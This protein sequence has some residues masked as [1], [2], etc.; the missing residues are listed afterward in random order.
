MSLSIYNCIYVPLIS[1]QSVLH[2]E[3]QSSSPTNAENIS[4]PQVTT[5]S[6]SA[7]E[8][9]DQILAKDSAQSVHNAWT[10]YY[11]QEGYPYYY[12]HISGESQWANVGEQNC[13]TMEE[14][15]KLYTYGIHTYESSKVTDDEQVKNMKTSGEYYSDVDDDDDIE[16]TESLGGENEYTEDDDDD[17]DDNNNKNGLPRRQKTHPNIENQFKEFLNTPEGQRRLQ[18]EVA[19]MAESFD[20]E[21]PMNN[22]YSGRRTA[23]KSMYNIMSPYTPSESAN[24]IGQNDFGNRVLSV[25]ASI[26]STLGYVVGSITAMATS[27]DS[28][29]KQN[30]P[31][32]VK[33]KVSTSTHLKEK[34]S[35]SDNTP[36]HQSR[37]HSFCNENIDDIE[38]FSSATNAV[39]PVVTAAQNDSTI[40]ESDSGSDSDSGCEDELT[41]ATAPLFPEWVSVS[42]FTAKAFDVVASIRGIAT[43]STS[44]PNSLE[45][46]TVKISDEAADNEFS[47]SEEHIVE[48]L[49]L[50][51]L[52]L[53]VS[54]MKSKAYVAF[55]AFASTALSVTEQV[56]VR[57]GTSVADIGGMLLSRFEVYHFLLLFFSL[58]VIQLIHA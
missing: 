31:V 5:S 20:P 11:S 43:S 3:S 39:N 25:A 10:L 41:V 32:N 37:K 49:P 17:D 33:V 58:S 22:L 47:E 21:T 46:S 9:K 36:S 16:E 34:Q 24:S 12:N 19:K 35:T 48:A 1:A 6:E 2:V 28:V 7:T 13:K 30:A 55:G 23:N 15:E 56:I 54:E 4:D 27:T 57:V 14:Q 40:D 50:S 52:N 45:S 38:S 8:P 26:G 53:N 18:V 51:I 42:V 44:K 29:E